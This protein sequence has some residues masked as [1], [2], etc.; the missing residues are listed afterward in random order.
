VKRLA[1]EAMEQKRKPKTFLIRHNK[2]KR[3][4]REFDRLS[5]TLSHLPESLGRMTLTCPFCGNVFGPDWFKKHDISMAPVK[6]RFEKKGVPYTGPARWILQ[7]VPQKCPKC[8]ANVMIDLP[9]SK[10]RT[11]GFLFGDDAERTYEGKT[12]FLYSLV[13]A[14]QSLLPELEKN[15][16][17]LKQNLIP[18]I[19]ADSWKIHMKDLW[20]GSSRKK[21]AVYSRLNM[22]GVVEFADSLLALIKKGN[23]FVYNIAVVSN[24]DDQKDKEERK[25]LRDE[26]FILL[27]LDVIDEWT[28]KNAQ[29]NIIFDSEKVSKA[30]ET[31]HGWARDVFLGNQ[32]TLLYG[33]LSKGIEIPEPRFV[34]PASS[35][36]L[37]LADFVSFAIGRYYFRRWQGKTIEIDPEKMGLVTYLGYAPNGDLLWRRRQG[38]PWNEFYEI[39]SYNKVNSADARSRAAD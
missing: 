19:P 30:S 13:G 39:G 7:Q 25:R 27:V 23:I 17:G 4:Q 16:K 6:P 26:L 34:P 1:T 3:Q 32:Y 12:V 20:A 28:T 10:I 22:N 29:P 15:I 18:S 33:F 8:T 36:G 2:T 9:I 21:H 38:Y 14:D 5:V 24:K 31:I 35:P 11:K 37:E